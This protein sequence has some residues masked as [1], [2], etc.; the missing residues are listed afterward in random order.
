[1]SGRTVKELLDTPFEAYL[2]A[3]Q[4]PQIA[5]I[6]RRR[7][8]GEDVPS[9]YEAAIQHR[10][11]SRVEVEFNAG[12]TTYDGRPATL[13]FV[14]DIRERV[15]ARQELEASQRLLSLVIDN[16]PAQISYV[17]K[18]QRYR[19]V[20]RRYEDAY[21]LPPS[22]FVGKP[23]Q[24]I[25]GPEGYAAAEK[26]IAAALA[27]ERISYEHVFHYPDRGQRWMSIDYVPDRYPAGDVQGFVGLVRDISESKQAEAALRESEEKLRAIYEAIP[28][29]AYTWQR[30]DEDFVLVDFNEMAAKTTEGRIVDLVGKRASEMYRDLPEIPEAMAR[31]SSERLTIEDEMDYQ[32]ITTVNRRYL[33]VKYAFAP[34]DLVVVHTEDITAR[35]RAEEELR[36]SNERLEEAQRTAQIGDWEYDILAGKVTWSDEMYRIRGVDPEQY[37]PTAKSD[38]EFCHPD[39]VP[40]LREA[41]ER[42]FAGGEPLDLDYRIVTP[43]GVAKACRRRGRLIVDDRGTPSLAIG[44]TEDITERWLVE[45]Q[46]TEYQQRLQSLASQ[47][48]L[49]EERER[50]RIARE[51]HDEVGQTLA[52][53]RTRLASARKTPSEARREAYLDDASRSLRQAIRDTR[54][55]VFDLSSPLMNELG[56]GAALREWLEDQVGKKHGLQTAFFYDGKRF[57]L[58]DDMRAILFRC[59]RELLT[60]VVKHAQAKQVTVRLEGDGALVRIA[61]EDD[62][63]RV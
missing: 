8:S 11:G 25:L 12:L 27:G 3:D 30:K 5:E 19:F 36:K 1:M 38:E 48:T 17:D 10:D 41:Y 21:G 13:V 35:K 53:A 28:V 63:D 44:T 49:S 2:A 22:E 40:A 50:R 6:Y 31:C 15:K 56:L 47:L 26:Q 58:D 60:N 18:R 62:G 43:Q 34:P 7:M 9:I 37:V 23:V 45:Q 14:R 52:F 51:L 16:V 42:F 39:D 4:L 61:V 59:S 55:L 24:E 57:P 33:N 46:I 29:A 20:N 54:D 32:L